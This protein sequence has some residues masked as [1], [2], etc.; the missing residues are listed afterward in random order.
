MIDIRPAYYHLESLGYSW[1]HGVIPGQNLDDP[2]DEDFSFDRERW[3]GRIFNPPPELGSEAEYDENA[4]PP[5]SYDE[6]L[7]FHDLS[8]LDGKKEQIIEEVNTQC[9]RRIAESYHPEGWGNRDK[10]WQARLKPGVDLTLPNAERERLIAVCH[11]LEE[12]I[13]A[14]SD[15]AALEEIDVTSEEVWEKS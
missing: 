6:I 4:M 8:V 2:K 11:S 1:P 15:V 7:H 5:L 10:E 12:K 9:T 14:A 13:R 3:E